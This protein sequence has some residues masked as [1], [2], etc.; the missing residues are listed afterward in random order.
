VWLGVNG[1]YHLRMRDQDAVEQNL[2]T[3][4]IERLYESQ[5]SATL[6]LTNRAWSARISGTYYGAVWYDTE[7]RL[8]VPQVEPVRNTIHRKSPFWTW[9]LGGRRAL[10]GGLWLTAAVD[11]L[12]NENNHPLFIAT[13]NA[14]ALSD[15]AFSNGGIGNSL[16]GRA[17]VVGLELRP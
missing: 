16:P 10:T 12:F 15:P 5:G 3:D 6:G 13:N 11:N 1:V 9:R 4:M 14:P 17:F 7:E 8:L 2:S